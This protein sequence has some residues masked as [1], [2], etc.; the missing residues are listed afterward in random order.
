VGVSPAD[1]G[2]LAEMNFTVANLSP[3]RKMEGR[4]GLPSRSLG[5]SGLV[6]NICLSTLN[7]PSVFRFPL[8]VFRFSAFSS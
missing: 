6:P 3:F 7:P 5:E 1:F 4:S 8:S 2:V